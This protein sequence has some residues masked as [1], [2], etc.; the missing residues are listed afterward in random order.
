M[1]SLWSESC[2]DQLNKDPLIASLTVCR[3]NMAQVR[4]QAATLVKYFMYPIRRVEGYIAPVIGVLAPRSAKELFV[5]CVVPTVTLAN[6]SHELTI[7]F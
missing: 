1:F 2:S 3:E 4:M 5:T 6:H 7:I